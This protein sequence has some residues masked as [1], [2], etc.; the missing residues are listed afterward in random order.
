MS[1]LTPSADTKKTASALKHAGFILVGSLLILAVWLARAIGGNECN[2]PY[3]NHQQLQI[4]GQTI[5][6]EKVS[7][8]EARQQGL[9]GRPCISPNQAMLFNFDK[10]GRYDFWMKD[11]R[12][13]IDIV[14]L[15]S[16]KTITEI[17]PSLDPSSY[18]QTFT[19]NEPSRFVLELP[20]GRAA[21]LNFQPGQTLNF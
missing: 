20:A 8:A 15:D 6:V 12:F 2:Y 9:S 19:S 18:P 14:W 1:N 21:Q 13:A 5:N 7:L 10:A 17:S 3:A 4:S 11:M 16:A